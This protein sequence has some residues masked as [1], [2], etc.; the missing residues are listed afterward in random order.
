MNHS[1]E[2]GVVR[3]AHFSDIHVMARGSWRAADL[4]NKRFSAWINLRVLGRARHFRQAEE[5]LAA[6]VEELRTRAFDRIV[7]SGDASAL[8][9]EEEVARAAKLLGVPHPE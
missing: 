1:E 2:P 5:V 3:L 9:F 4:F 6:L 8:G 7:F